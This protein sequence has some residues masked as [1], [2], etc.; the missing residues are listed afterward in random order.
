MWR[1]C[2]EQHVKGR[3]VNLSCLRVPPFERHPV[4]TVSLL[5]LSIYFLFYLLIKLFFK[6]GHL[7]LCYKK[8]RVK[9]ISL[10]TANRSC[11]WH[12][13]STAHPMDTTTSINLVIALLLSCDLCHHTSM[14]GCIAWE[15]LILRFQL[16]G[17][18]FLTFWIGPLQRATRLQLRVA[19]IIARK[20]KAIGIGNTAY[21]YI[22]VQAATPIKQ[23]RY[24]CTMSCCSWLSRLMDGSQPIRKQEVKSACFNPCESVFWYKSRRFVL[25]EF[26]AHSRW[27]ESTHFLQLIRWA[28][29]WQIRLYHCLVTDEADHPNPDLALGIGHPKV[30][31]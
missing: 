18:D 20:L 15:A 23:S 1:A 4:W 2:E 11:F 3:C 17:E 10:R 27:P 9:N 13:D 5:Y 30:P 31:W 14:H 25:M 26:I 6:H 8:P 29:L 21:R 22:K 12:C 7:R 16:P 28:I 19:T 24:R